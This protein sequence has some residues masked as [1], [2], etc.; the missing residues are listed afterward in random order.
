MLQLEL[1][2]EGNGVLP[3]LPPKK[4]LKAHIREGWSLTS[5]FF[6]FQCGISK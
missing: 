2:Q 1:K 4:M 3:L 5:F 6:F